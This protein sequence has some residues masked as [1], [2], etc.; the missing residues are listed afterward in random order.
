MVSKRMFRK[1]L[2]KEV[3]NVICDLKQIDVI[4]SSTN[5]DSIDVVPSIRASHEIKELGAFIPFF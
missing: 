2:F 3:G 4:F 5:N 1:K